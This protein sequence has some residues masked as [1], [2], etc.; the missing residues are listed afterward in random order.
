M[1]IAQ[2]AFDR[3]SRDWRLRLIG[4]GSPAHPTGWR[5][6]PLTDVT[7]IIRTAETRLRHCGF[8]PSG[9]AWVRIHDEWLMPVAPID[10]ANSPDGAT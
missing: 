7:E 9:I 10:T 3:A 5:L 1:L 6:D 2:V 4:G 8:A